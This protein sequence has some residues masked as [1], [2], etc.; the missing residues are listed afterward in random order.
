MAQKNT[1]TIVLTMDEPKSP[2]RLAEYITENTDLEVAPQRMYQYIRSGKL[3]AV[4]NEL[5]H[6]VI[7]V[8]NG[9]AFLEWFLDPDRGKKKA[10]ENVTE[11][12]AAS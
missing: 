2:Y 12:V 9:N 11:E 6:K 1:P 4:I 5:G 7:T 8:E 3:V 10:A